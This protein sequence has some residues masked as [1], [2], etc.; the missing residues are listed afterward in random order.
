MVHEAHLPIIGIDLF[1]LKKALSETEKKAFIGRKGKC[2]SFPDPKDDW[3][4]M[5]ST[6]QKSH[7][8]SQMALAQA[9]LHETKRPLKKNIKSVLFFLSRD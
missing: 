3:K 5:Q 8:K 9:E 7:P 6:C 4:Q 1:R 2:I